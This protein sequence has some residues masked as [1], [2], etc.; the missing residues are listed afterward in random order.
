MSANLSVLCR[1]ACSLTSAINQTTDN[2]DFSDGIR[3][4]GSLAKALSRE[5]FIGRRTKTKASAN[6]DA[7]NKLSVLAR[8]NFSL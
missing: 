5:V 8:E 4:L 3:A 1:V 6:V 7:N 2:S